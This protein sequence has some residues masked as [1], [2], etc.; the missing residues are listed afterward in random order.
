VVGADIDGKSDEGPAGSVRMVTVDVGRRDASEKL[1]EIA[2]EEF[3][4]LDVWINNA[5]IY[6]SSPLIDLDDKSWDEVLNV[7]LSAMFRGARAAARVMRDR[8]GGVI[9]NMASNAGMAA[10][11]GSAHYV[12][13]KH[14][15]V[16]LTKSL[17]VDL[18]PFGIRSVGIAPG[19][20]R[21]EGIDDATAA[22]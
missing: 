4:A 18:A 2:L 13:S 19:V 17:A 20:T 15:V 3:G 8:G 5:G 1:A 16:G 22:R 10:G 9:V 6:P 21:T 11:P 12:S 7:N 14:G